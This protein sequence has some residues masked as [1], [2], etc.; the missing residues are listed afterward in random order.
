M[1]LLLDTH[2]V[3]WWLDRPEG[4]AATTRVEIGNPRNAVYFSAVSMFEIA[5]K[6]AVGKLRMTDDFREQLASCRFID[7]SVTVP[8]A[9]AV[10]RLPPVHRDP[11]DRLLVAQAV[12]EGLTLVTRD[13]A[14]ARY[15]VPVLTA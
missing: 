5:A 2:V 14:I 15:E 3:L 6:E 12:V 4:I 1:K 7:L 13:A 9:D 10:R 11:F 8:H